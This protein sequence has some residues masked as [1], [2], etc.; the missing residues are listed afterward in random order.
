MTADEWE[1]RVKPC[2]GCTP[3]PSSEQLGE[4]LWAVE[5]PLKSVMVVGTDFNK[6]AMAKGSS[7]IG[8]VASSNFQ[9]AR[10]YSCCMLQ[11]SGSNT[12]NC[13]QV[14]M[15]DAVSKLQ[16]CN[17]QLDHKTKMYRDGVGDGQ[18]KMVVNFEV[19][20]ILSAPDECSSGCRRAKLSVVVI[21]KKCRHRFFIETNR[22]LQ[23]PPIGT[24]FDTEATRPEWYDFF[25]SSQ[26]ACQGT[27][28][29]TYYNVVYDDNGF[30][31]DHMQHL[32]YKMCHMYYNWPGLIRVPAPCHYANKL[33]FLVGQSIHREPSLA[34]AD[35]LFYL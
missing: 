8:F 7:V 29:P 5:I 14:C 27:V 22:S 18:L 19:P 21:R 11:N 26:L 16:A 28:N 23:N 33:T 15:K 20:Q 34:L 1:D 3:V 10:L 24:V 2:I 17:G 13:L 4:E 9:L 32:T 12:A 35:K 25:L 30:N 31:P 6:D